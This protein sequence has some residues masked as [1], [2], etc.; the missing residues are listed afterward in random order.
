MAMPLKTSPSIVMKC[1]TLLPC[2]AN[3][4]GLRR[5]Q[6]RDK[7]AITNNFPVCLK[8]ENVNDTTT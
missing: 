5:S 2:C 6:V 1:K 8:G 7:E 4:A 3:E